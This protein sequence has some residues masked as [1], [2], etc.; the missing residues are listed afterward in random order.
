MQHKC[1]IGGS[2]S[3]CLNV[4]LV[5]GVCVVPWDIRAI[6]STRLTDTKHKLEHD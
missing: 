2:R 6:M 5:A 1:Y 3:G 4:T